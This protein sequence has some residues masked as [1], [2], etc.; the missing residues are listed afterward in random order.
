MPARTTRRICA[1]ENGPTGL[2]DTRMPSADT[3]GGIDG[4]S[5]GGVRGNAGMCSVSQFTCTNVVSGSSHGE[6]AS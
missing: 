5:A 4:C 1:S 6:V 2:S 3:Y